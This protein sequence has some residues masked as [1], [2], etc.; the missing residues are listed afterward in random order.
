MNKQI[1]GICTQILWKYGTR[2]YVYY[3]CKLSNF[4]FQL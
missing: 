2:F 3:A 1:T 4:F